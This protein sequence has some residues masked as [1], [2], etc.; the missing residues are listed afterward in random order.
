MKK[1]TLIMLTSIV[2]ISVIVVILFM[3]TYL[4]V[5]SDSENPL[6]QSEE[7][8]L[9]E[10][11]ALTPIGTSLEDVRR[12]LEADN[13]QQNWDDVRIF[14]Q[15]GV[16]VRGVRMWRN[17]PNS[18]EQL[19]DFNTQGREPVV[20][21]HSVQAVMGEYI[22]FPIGS[23]QVIVWWAFDANFNLIDVFVQKQTDSL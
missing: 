8:L 14:Q 16:P 22:M 7:S 11:L 18:D 3:K 10:V 20:G 19:L 12:I 2:V 4:T 23:T 1:A 21:E 15:R 6:R 5:S 17:R 9:E 13:A